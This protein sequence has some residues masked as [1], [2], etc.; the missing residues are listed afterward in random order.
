MVYIWKRE[1][2]AIA[3]MLSACNETEQAH[4]HTNLFVK[5]LTN[6]KEFE[7][8]KMKPLFLFFSASPPVVRSHAASL[9][10]HTSQSKPAGFY[11][12]LAKINSRVAITS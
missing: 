2:A 12:P 1:H 8:G 3:A 5:N 7:N 4:T 6:R 9:Y 11:R 10:P